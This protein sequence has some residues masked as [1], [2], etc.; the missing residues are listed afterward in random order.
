[1]VSADRTTFRT[2]SVW[3]VVLVVL[4]FPLR[5]LVTVSWAIGFR[6]MVYDGLM[7]RG[8]TTTA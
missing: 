5:Y 8:T 6:V 1:M 4:G 7:D 2:R 3:L